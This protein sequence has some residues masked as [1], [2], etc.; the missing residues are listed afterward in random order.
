MHLFFWIPAI[1]GLVLIPV[2][3]FY[4]AFVF[5]K[6]GYNPIVQLDTFFPQEGPEY[7]WKG[8]EVIYDYLASSPIE[9]VLLGYCAAAIPISLYLEL[10]D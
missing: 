10:R 1:I 9:L 3:L 6:H 7:S 2:S 8:V 5:L 4:R